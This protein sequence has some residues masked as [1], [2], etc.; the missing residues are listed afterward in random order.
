MRPVRDADNSPPAS[1]KVK[2]MWSYAPNPPAYAFLVRTATKLKHFA[3]SNSAETKKKNIAN[4]YMDV[5][6]TLTP[7]KLGPS[8][9]HQYFKKKMRFIEEWNKSSIHIMVMTV[10]QIRKDSLR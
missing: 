6:L 7:S 10:L 8:K 2:N 3:L 4:R 9:L 5:R 1:V